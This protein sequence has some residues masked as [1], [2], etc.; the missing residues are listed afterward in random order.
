[1]EINKY[2]SCFKNRT[3]QDISN[4]YHSLEKHVQMLEHFKKEAKNFK[5][6]KQDEHE[7]FP[8]IFFAEKW[9][10]NEVRKLK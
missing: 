6:F 2:R 3:F 8:D 1:M 5:G 9:S 7:S 4:K 10:F